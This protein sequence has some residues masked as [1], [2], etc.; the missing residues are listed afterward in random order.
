[1]MSVPAFWLMERH[2]VWS[3]DSSNAISLPLQHDLSIHCMFGWWKMVE[4]FWG[5]GALCEAIFWGNS[6]GFLRKAWWQEW[7][8][9][10]GASLKD[11]VSALIV[12]V[13]GVSRKPLWSTLEASKLSDVS[14]SF[15]DAEHRLRA[16]LEKLKKLEEAAGSSGVVRSDR[17]G[18]KI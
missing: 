11:S 14:M 15:Q 12:A 18:D 17:S 13:V 3:L 5:L 1:M 7:K 8:P 9:N 16:D 4:L 6:L 10:L 2:F